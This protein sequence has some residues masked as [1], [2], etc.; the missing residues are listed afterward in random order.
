MKVWLITLCNQNGHKHTITLATEDDYLRFMKDLPKG[1]DVLTIDERLAS[2]YRQAIEY[3]EDLAT[4]VD[5][6]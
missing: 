1:L 4:E 6:S 5:P 3:A 2:S